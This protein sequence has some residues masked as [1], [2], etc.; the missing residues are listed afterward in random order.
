MAI[1]EADGAP[2]L[3]AASERTSACVL[4]SMLHG[5]HVCTLVARTEYLQQLDRAYQMQYSK[6]TALQ[7]KQQK[8]RR[9][10]ARRGSHPR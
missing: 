6:L 1:G 5:K 8:R 4:D 7:A 3:A 9:A 2:R 10:Q